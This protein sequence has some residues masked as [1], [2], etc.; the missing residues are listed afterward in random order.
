MALFTGTSKASNVLIASNMVCLLADFECSIGVVGTG[1]WR[2]PKI[3]EACKHV[4][5]SMKAELFTKAVDIYSYGMTCYEILTS[6]L[7]F[8][9]RSWNDYD[10]ILQRQRPKVPNYIDGW[11]W[12]LLNRCWQSNPIARPSSQEILKIL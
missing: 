5:V 2:V 11:I 6:K 4:N 8:E 10:S 1:F 3:L 7:L 9:G 12:K